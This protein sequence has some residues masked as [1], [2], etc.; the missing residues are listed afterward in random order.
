MLIVEAEGAEVGGVQTGG[1][2]TAYS[3]LGIYGRTNLAT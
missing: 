1:G 2:N 3:L